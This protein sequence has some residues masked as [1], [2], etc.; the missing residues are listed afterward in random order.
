M[1]EIEIG[2]LRGQCLDRRNRRLKLAPPRNR[3]LGTT[4]KR[5]R[6]PH[7]LDVHN[8]Q[9]PAPKWAALI[10]SLPKSHNH[11]GEVL[12]ELCRADVRIVGPIAWVLSSRCCRPPRLFDGDNQ[13]AEAAQDVVQRALFRLDLE[14]LDLPGE[15][16]E[17]GT[18]S[19]AW[20]DSC[21][22]HMCGPAPNAM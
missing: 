14:A 20:R 15:R 19:P 21:Q 16:G 10:P 17:E 22:G 12:G 5:H 6:R 1:V 13:L 18:Q 8:R 2:V 3:R 4:T 7:Q 11:C 9:S